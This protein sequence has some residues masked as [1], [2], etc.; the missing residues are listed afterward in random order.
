M[1]ATKRPDSL[2]RE[3]AHGRVQCN[4][5]VGRHITRRADAPA[6]QRDNVRQ[7]AL[8][9]ELREDGPGAQRIIAQFAC[10]EGETRG[11]WPQQL[12]AEESGLY[13]WDQIVF[14]VVAS[15]A[16]TSLIPCTVYMTPSTTSGVTSCFSSDFAWKT[17]FSVRSLA[18]S[19]VMSVK[20]L[21]RWLITEPE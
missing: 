12:R 6:I 15:S 20:A 18:F 17:H 9:R 1:T 13:A 8:H 21:W 16:I 19:G 10:R 3:R 2:A 5:E 7:T 14:P 4:A 11:A